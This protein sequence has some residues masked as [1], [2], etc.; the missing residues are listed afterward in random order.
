MHGKYLAVYAALVCLLILSGC[1]GR[2]QVFNPPVPPGSAAPVAA[3]VLPEPSA[4]YQQLPARSAS[5][6]A[7]V[8][9]G[10]AFEPVL[11]LRV[12]ALGDAAEFSPQCGDGEPAAQTLACALYRLSGQG[13]PGA[14]VLHTLWDVAP[15]DYADAWLGLANWNAERWDWYPLATAGTAQMPAAG[16][17]AYRLPASGEMLAAVVLTGAAPARLRELRVGGSVPYAAGGCVLRADGSGVMGVPLKLDGGPGQVHSDFGGLWQFS[18]LSAG[19]YTVTPELPRICFEPP[20]REFTMIFDYVP[21]G[22]FTLASWNHSWGTAGAGELECAASVCFDAAGNLLVSGQANSPTQYNALCMKYNADG[23]LQWA[24]RMRPAGSQFTASVARDNAVDSAGNIYLATF[25]G[26]LKLDS[27]GELLW[28]KGVCAIPDMPVAGS[29]VALRADEGIY[30]ASAFSTGTSRSEMLLYSFNPEGGLEHLY[31]YASSYSLL[32][33]ALTVDADGNALLLA[34]ARPAP[35]SEDI[36]WAVIKA[37][38]L[39]QQIWVKRWAATS[40]VDI[41]A[42]IAVDAANNL[43]LAGGMQG[44]EPNFWIPVLQKLSPNG[45]PLWQRQWEVSPEFTGAIT[46]LGVWSGT[47]YAYGGS[48]L[49]LFNLDGDLLQQ[50]DIS[51]APAVA[52]YMG[53]LAVGPSGEVAMA[54]D[55]WHTADNTW[56]EEAGNS[57]PLDLPWDPLSCTVSALQFTIQDFPIIVEDAA[58][59]VDILDYGEDVGLLYHIAFDPQ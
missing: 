36:D 7:L 10:S 30:V 25:P 44:A 28:A 54:G 20:N 48:H 15:A 6:A 17:T 26:I 57:Q 3:G 38:P 55:A 5:A 59:Q 40:A 27:A 46:G 22:D 35:Y 4:L 49:A 39:C 2:M 29:C 13:Y 56:I 32:P 11:C 19:S 52:Y 47:V 53:D 23:E 8:V 9:R 16:F 24:K 12:A 34:Q 43:Y 58:G 42:C 50:F 51:V 21:V 33:Q 31:R 1:A 18:G 45:E 37:G 41:P 14:A